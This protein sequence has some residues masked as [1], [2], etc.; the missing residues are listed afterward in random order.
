MTTAKITVTARIKAKTGSK[1]QLKEVLLAQAAESRKDKGCI[2]FDLYVNET[3]DTEFA[4]HEAWES[5]EDLAAHLKMPY[6]P[7]YREKRAPFV[8]GAPEVVVWK[9]VE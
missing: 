9:L 6:L 5:R 1:E 3:D 8:D 2:R 4:F 7:V